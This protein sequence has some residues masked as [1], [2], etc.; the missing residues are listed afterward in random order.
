MSLFISLLIWATR[1][2]KIQSL[3]VPWNLSFFVCFSQWSVFLLSVSLSAPLLSHFIPLS[4]S[5]LIHTWL[6]SKR[7]GLN[8][9]PGA[10]DEPA[11]DTGPFWEIGLRG[12]KVQRRRGIRQWVTPRGR[13]HSKGDYEK[14]GGTCGKSSDVQRRACKYGGDEVSGCRQN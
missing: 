13:E 7:L 1:K 4:L 6:E 5:L 10:P 12:G 3:L 14:G 9:P 11:R 2:T 8:S